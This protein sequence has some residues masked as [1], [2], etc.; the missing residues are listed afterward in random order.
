MNYLA[1]N[2]LLPG[3]IS[4]TGSLKEGYNYILASKSLSTK[5]SCTCNYG[6]KLPS[7]LVI[8]LLS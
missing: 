6:L 3:G 5:W 7:R 1:V 4:L 2:K 8:S